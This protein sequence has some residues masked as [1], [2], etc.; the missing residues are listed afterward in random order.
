M[1]RALD[2]YNQK[3]PRCNM[4]RV[5]H[6]S[7]ELSCPMPR[8]FA[9][10]TRNDLLQTW[11]ATAA[12]VQPEVAGKY[13]LFW[14]P[15]DRENDSTLGCKVTA[16]A[17]EIFVAFEWKS[18]KQ[19]KA[20]ANSA[21]PLTHVVVTFTPSQHGTRVDLVHSGWRSS[22]KWQAAA[23]WQYQAWQHAFTNLESGIR[24]DGA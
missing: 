2:A 14:D 16:I 1:F 3:N 8:A 19:F 10:F 13:E 17:P 18:P 11:L 22:A 5:I 4:D 15:S 12:D 9:Y 7:A 24:A 21:D 23:D 6:C 20:L